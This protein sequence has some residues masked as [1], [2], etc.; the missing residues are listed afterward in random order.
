MTTLRQKI[1]A[2]VQRRFPQKKTL[3]SKLVNVIEK[4]ENLEEVLFQ[5][6]LIQTAEE[7]QNCLLEV[8]QKDE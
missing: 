2:L 8:I 1:L 3:A 4:P 5:L 6:A 7:V